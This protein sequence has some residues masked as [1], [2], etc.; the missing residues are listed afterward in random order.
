[1]FWRDEV[2]RDNDFR[3]FLDSGTHDNGTDK[4]VVVVVKDTDNEGYQDFLRAPFE[5]QYNKVIAHQDMIFD[6]PDRVPIWRRP[7]GPRWPKTSNSLKWRGIT[8]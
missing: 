3:R 4:V 6:N 5:C 7:E 8:S 1:M 2:E